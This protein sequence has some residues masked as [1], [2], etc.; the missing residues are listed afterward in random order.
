MC[1]LSELTNQVNKRIAKSIS[2]LT[3]ILVNELSVSSIKVV[4]LIWL[5]IFNRI[6]KVH[7]AWIQIIRKEL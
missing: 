3:C 5:G 1:G 2:R 4:R 6:S 7:M